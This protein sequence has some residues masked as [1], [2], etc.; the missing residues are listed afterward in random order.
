MMTSDVLTTHVPA[1][2]R[3]ILIALKERGGM[4][5]DELAEKLGISSVAVR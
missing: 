2:R 5:A 4:T 1:T 3:R